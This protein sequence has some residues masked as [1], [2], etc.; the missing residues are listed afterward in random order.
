MNLSENTTVIAHVPLSRNAQRKSRVEQTAVIR[1]RT[2]HLSLLARDEMADENLTVFDGS[3]RWEQLRPA[4]EAH[5]IQENIE[6]RMHATRTVLN[7]VSI[8]GSEMERTKIIQAPSFKR[9]NPSNVSSLLK[10]IYSRIK[11]IF[12]QFREPL[13]KAVT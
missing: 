12:D 1:Q 9:Q 8:L 4:I 10:N 13:K 2:P 7:G 3:V 6:S 11:N 5:R